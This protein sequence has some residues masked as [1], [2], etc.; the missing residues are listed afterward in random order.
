MKLIIETISNGWLVYEKDGRN[1]VNLTAFTY[2]DMDE[3]ANKVGHFADV[4]YYL[5]DILGPTTSRY[6]KARIYVKV[7]PGDKCEERS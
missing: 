5:N 2:N 7:E 6:D 1:K 3:E 4:L